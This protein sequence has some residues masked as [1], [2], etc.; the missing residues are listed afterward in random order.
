MDSHTDGFPG[1]P[2]PVLATDL[3]GRLASLNLDYLELLCAETHR[4]GPGGMPDLPERVLAALRK[5]DRA[6]R[7]L[8]ASTAFSLYSLGFEDQQ[9]WRSALRMDR[10]VDL[11]P[12]DARYGVASAVLVQSSFCEIALLHAW[13]VAVSQPTAA[14]LIYGMPATLVERMRTVQLWQLRRIAVDYPRLLT[15][16]WSAHPCFWPEMIK[17]AVTGDARRLHTLQQLGHQLLAVD[18]QASSDRC[19]A[20]R[21]RQHNLLKQRLQHSRSPR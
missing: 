11:L 9:F 19:G 2:A 16:R 12:V 5:A 7:Q 10:S 14:R 13:H 8:L 6:A 15:P 4:L 1:A 17:F 21:Q 20:V 18:L 3:L